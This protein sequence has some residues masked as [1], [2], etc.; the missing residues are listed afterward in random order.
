M[1]DPEV[2]PSSTC[3]AAAQFPQTLWSVVLAAGSNSSPRSQEALATLCHTYW[4]PIYA[5]LRRG[6]QSPH[7]AEDLTQ[8][9]LAHL[10]QNQRLSRVGREKGKFRSFLLA[11]LKNFLMD[12]AKKAHAQK[13]GGARAPVSLDAAT[14]E[15]RYAL[16][17]PEVLNPEKIYER[18]W[19]MMVIER[20]LERLKAESAEAGTA[21]RFAQLQPLLLLEN[22]EESYAEV[23]M[24]L[25]MT[26]GAVKMALLRLRQRSREL[27][28][29]EIAHTVASVD[30]IE[31]EVRHLF[32]VL[33]G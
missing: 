9:F 30:E 23:G 29:S 28:R 17:P 6:G 3:V 2:S 1:A 20:V 33:A 25:G 11:S 21:E 14:A 15:E 27:F 26:E 8:G 19:A 16:E 18:R 12:G 22:R 31:E 32:A 13:R 5:F 4:Y 24:R 10:C 7:D